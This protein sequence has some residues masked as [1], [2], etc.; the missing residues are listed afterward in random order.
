MLIDWTQRE[1]FFFFSE[2]GIALPSKAVFPDEFML[3]THLLV[4][5]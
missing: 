1:R 4:K 2:K 5:D 3:I